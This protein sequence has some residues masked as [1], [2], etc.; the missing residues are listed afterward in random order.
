M[1]PSLKAELQLNTSVVVCHVQF[2]FAGKM[3]DIKGNR[4]KWWSNGT[5]VNFERKSVCLV[6]QYSNFTFYGRK[7]NY[8]FCH[9]KQIHELV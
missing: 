5:L 6:D 2:F 1:L 3:F 9:L 4:R 8:Y 7:V